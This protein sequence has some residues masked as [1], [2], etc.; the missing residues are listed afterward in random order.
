MAAF[1]FQIS[2]RHRDVC[3]TADAAK[4]PDEA[5][6]KMAAVMLRWG[7]CM[8]LQSSLFSRNFQALQTV[9]WQWL[10]A[11]GLVWIDM[12]GFF[13]YGDRLLLAVYAEKAVQL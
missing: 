6:G 3:P 9:A 11:G 13:G 1:P 12:V 2:G 10:G 4:F 7:F 8:F 5:Q